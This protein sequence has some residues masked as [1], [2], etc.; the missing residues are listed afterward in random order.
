MRIAFWIVGVLVLVLVAAWVFGPREPLDRTGFDE[1][2]LPEDLDAYLALKEATQTDVTPGA[3]KEIVWAGAPGERTPLAIVYLHGFSATKQEIRPVPDMLASRFGANIYYARFAG[4][5]QGGERLAEATAG[6]WLRD[7]EEALAIGRRLGERVLVVATSTGATFGTLAL[8]KPE[9]ARGVVGLAAVSPN[10]GIRGAPLALLT[11]P[12]ARQILP[13]VFGAERSWTPDNEAHGRW[14]TTRYPLVALL[15]MARGVEAAREAVLETI[16][17]PALFVFSDEDEVVDAAAT[18]AVAARWGSEAAG[19]AG[20]SISVVTPGPDDAKSRH[21]IA[22]DILSPGM[23]GEVAGI[24][25][26]WVEAL[27]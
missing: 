23:T 1:A 19:A 21:V 15:P 4:H 8:L 17:T 24:I 12:F 20:V 27:R 9:A 6:D 7:A 10:F 18:R 26:D 22:G 11:A 16:A 2:N 14:W 3:E 13:L 25:G 5:G